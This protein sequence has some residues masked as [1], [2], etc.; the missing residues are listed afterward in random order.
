MIIIIN[1]LYI[2]IFNENALYLAILRGNIDII[3][4]LL[5]KKETNVN[6]KFILNK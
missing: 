4:F 3:K 6:R 5:N 2:Y 1:S